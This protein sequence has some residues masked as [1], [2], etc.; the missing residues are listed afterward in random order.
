MY[1]YIYIE[2]NKYIIKLNKNSE[3]NKLSHNKMI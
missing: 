1:I 3:N 2:L